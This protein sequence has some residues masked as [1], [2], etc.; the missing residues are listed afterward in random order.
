MKKYKS[1][2]FQFTFLDDDFHLF[3]KVTHVT[4]WNNVHIG[5]DFMHTEIKWI[6]KGNSN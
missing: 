4:V 3:P 2:L 6:V 1:Q 5:T